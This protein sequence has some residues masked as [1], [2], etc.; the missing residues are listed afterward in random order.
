MLDCTHLENVSSFEHSISWKSIAKVNTP[1]LFFFHLVENT[2]QST[3]LASKYLI[4][5]T[6]TF[7]NIHNSYELPKEIWITQNIEKYWLRE[8]GKHTTRKNIYIYISINN[9]V[10]TEKWTCSTCWTKP[11]LDCYYTFPFD[12][13]SSGISY[14]AKSIGKM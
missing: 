9:I 8:R 7:Q 14:D 5:P 1:K 6:K 4:I 2:W 13:A 11:N 12:L 10:H 3:I